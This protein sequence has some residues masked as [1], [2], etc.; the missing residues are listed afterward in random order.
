M[1][2]SP[3][4]LLALLLTAGT[5][6]TTLLQ[7]HAADMHE[8]DQGP[9]HAHASADGHDDEPESEHA[10]GH[11]HDDHAEVAPRGPHGG[12][13]LAHDGFALEITLYETGVPPEFHVYAYDDG[14]PVAPEAVT[15]QIALA[16]LGGRT[17]RFDFLPQTDYLRG[18]GEVGEPHS[19]DVSVMARYRDRDYQWHYES[20]E[21][22]THIAAAMAR[23]AGIATATAGPTGIRE[24]LV[25][26]GR[27]R[28]DPDRLSRVR[29]RFPGVIQSLR[30]ELGDTVQAG[31]TLASVQSNESLQNYAVQAPIGGVIVTRSA[32]VGEAT[33]DD[34][35]FV[36]ADLSQVWV[37]LDVFGRDLQRVR[38]GQAVA[39]ETFDGY[40]ANGVIDWV[41]PLATH[42][43]QSVSARV[44]L[45]NPDGALRPGQFAQGEVTVAEHTVPLAVRQSAVQRFR[46][47]AVVFARYGE[48]YEVRMLETGR[49]NREWIEVLGGL[50][51]GTEYVT[52]NSYLIKADIE[53]AG[54]GHEH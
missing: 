29:A 48:T 1:K 21:G 51:P 9:A 14:A 10:H 20:H 40:R 52:V 37:E 32:Q 6:T 41:S 39:I 3:H 26:T 11:G 50:E 16:R 44:R 38:A 13:L 43:S 23:E 49:H 28:T 4:L 18:Q 31:D 8:H 54:A 42:A 45:P 27:V 12:R 34:P 36:I 24:T 17:D 15:L 19:F 33:G 30:R 46:D 35:L 7:L 5:A 53:K 22:R 2:R 47:A 25:L